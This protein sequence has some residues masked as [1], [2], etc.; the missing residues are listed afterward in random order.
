M[1]LI[2][3]WAIR[4]YF[5]LIHLAAYFR[6]DA[7]KWVNGRE[8]LLEQI[9]PFQSVSKKYF[10]IH[11]SSLGEFEQVRSLIEMIKLH[12]PDQ[13]IWLSFFSPSGYDIR[14]QYPFVDVVSYWPSDVQSEVLQFIDIV[15]PSCALFVKYDFWFNT[16][17]ILHQRK[18][19]MYYIS[20]LFHSKTY[21]TK[22]PFG[23]LLN[24][25]K[26]F[27]QLFVQDQFTYQ[28][29][30]HRQFLNIQRS[31]DT[32]MDRITDIVSAHQPIEEIESYIN[33]RNVFIAGSIWPEDDPFLLKLID[34]EIAKDWV[35]ILVPHHVDEAN[36]I[37]IENSY[38]Y[39]ITRF[40]NIKSAKGSILLMDQI[41]LLSSLY[42]YAK[43]AYVGGGFGKNIHNILEP[44]GHHIP[45]A[46]GPAHK[47]FVEAQA[48]IDAGFGF[49]IKHLQDLPSLMKLVLDATWYENTISAIPI[50]WNNHSGATKRIYQ[51]LK[52]ENRFNQ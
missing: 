20:L 21:L 51:Y 30:A 38:H 4:I 3:D 35:I 49:E 13:L 34:S 43:F 37:R 1:L 48:F 32:R 25:L 19:P 46:F 17:E 44:A 8:H 14:K 26:A 12:H 9:K 18:I 22:W 33:H 23:A 42:Q 41:G 47:K 39:P 27:D 50:Y 16:F 45:V 10:W 6:T 11:C 2:Y 29:L 52:Q 31:G 5:N 40:K 7:K 24:R 36:L 15:S 28:F